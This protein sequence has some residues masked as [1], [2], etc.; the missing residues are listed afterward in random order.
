MEKLEVSVKDVE[1]NMMNLAE[2]LEFIADCVIDMDSTNWMW[3]P[4]VCYAML[5]ERVEHIYVRAGEL[6][7]E[8]GLKEIDPEK[9]KIISEGIESIGNGIEK[10]SSL[11]EEKTE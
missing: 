2:S 9:A 4:D 1:S 3:K 5:K 11:S 7:L 10:L 6:F 8:F